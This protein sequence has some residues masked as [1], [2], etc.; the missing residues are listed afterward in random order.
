MREFATTEKFVNKT[1]RAKKTRA[2]RR[3]L[4]VDELKI[5]T[6]RQQ[7]KDSNYPI[8]KFALKA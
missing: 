8:R 6:L 7:K 4:T 2:I 3:K 1:L 5:K